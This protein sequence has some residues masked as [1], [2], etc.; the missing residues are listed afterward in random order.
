MS[1]S[2]SEHVNKSSSSPHSPS[3]P[4]DTTQGAYRPSSASPI[5]PSAYQY[6]GTTATRDAAPSRSSRHSEGYPSWLPRRPPP[7]APA[8]TVGT[9]TPAPFDRDY[10]A[11]DEDLD[12]DAEMRHLD[13]Q[14]GEFG[15]LDRPLTG[16]DADEEE[17]SPV[18]PNPLLLG[19][20]KPTPRSVRIVNLERA[21]A[22]MQITEELRTPKAAATAAGQGRPHSHPS[23]AT[24][25]AYWKGRQN[26]VSSGSTAVAHPGA[27]AVP[28][29]GWPRPHTMFDSVA[30]SWFPPGA[31]PDS[32]EPRPRP[33]FN[34]RGLH[35]EL[36]R[37]PSLWMKVY[38]RLWPLLVLAHLPL[39]TFLDFNTA[40]MLIQVSKYPLPNSAPSSSKNWALG[41]AA[42]IA[43]WLVWILVIFV[44]YELVYSF[45][46]KWR[47]RRPLIFPLYLSSP[48]YTF[49]CMTSFNTFCF[50]QH[51][52]WTA[53][54]PIS[55][56][57]P[58]ASTSPRSSVEDARRRDEVDEDPEKEIEREVAA[59]QGQQHHH[60]T[61]SASSSGSSAQEDD[62]ALGRHRRSSSSP[63]NGNDKKTPL[64]VQWKKN[65]KHTRRFW[66]QITWRDGLAETFNLYAQNLPNVV[67]LLPRAGLAL[68]LLLM[69][70]SSV[71]AGPSSSTAASRRE[72]TFFDRD[73]MLSNYA[74]GI[75]WAN[76]AWTAWR[77]G[78]LFVSWVGLWILSGHA[79]AG[80]CGPRDK[81]EEEE[82]H[83][84]SASL[85]RSRR[86]PY[87]TEEEV[88]EGK[89]Q[90]APRANGHKKTTSKTPLGPHKRKP[91]WY[92]M[93][94]SVDDDDDILPWQWRECTRARV[95]DAWEFCVVGDGGR[96]R[97]GVDSK[98]L[99]TIPAS[100]DR[101]PSTPP[102]S[103]NRRL[104][105]DKG[106][107]LDDM[108]VQ[109]VLAAVGIPTPGV[110]TPAKRG[111]LRKELFEAPGSPTKR[112]GG[113]PVLTSPTMLGREDEDDGRE[114]DGA[115]RKS[116]LP[117][118]KLPYPFAQQ[119]SGYVSSKE[120]VAESGTGVPFPAKEKKTS[121]KKS[122]S[123]GSSAKSGSS[124]S[125]DKSQ[126][127]DD[128]DHDDEQE[129]EGEP[130]P[131]SSSHNY[132]SES[133]SSSPVSSRNRRA[134][135]H[136][137]ESNSMSSLGNP[138]APSSAAFV[139]RGF[140][141]PPK[142]Q[143]TVSGGTAYTAT[144]SA[145]GTQGHG[146]RSS[147]GS[148]VTNI[149]STSG[150]GGTSGERGG[151]S[152]ASP[153]GARTRFPFL[154]GP[155]V[156][157]SPSSPGGGVVGIG[158]TGPSTHFGVHGRRVTVQHTGGTTTSGTTSGHSRGLSHASGFS[159]LSNLS[160]GV[161]SDQGY[162]AS[163]SGEGDGDLDVEMEI[164]EEAARHQQDP[165]IT[166]R[167]RT[168][169]NESGQSA[170]SGVIPM[171]RRHPHAGR[172][173]TSPAASAPGAS[174]GSD[175]GSGSA[176]SKSS[177]SRPGGIAFP[178]SDVENTTTE[179]GMVTGYA[180]GRLGMEMLSIEASDSLARRVRE[181]AARGGIPV[182]HDDEDDENE[183]DHDNTQPREAGGN[184]EE[185]QDNDDMYVDD[186]D[187]KSDGLGELDEEA[188]G[189]REDRVGLLTL[190][191]SPSAASLHHS[192]RSSALAV[193]QLG[194]LLP[195]AIAGSSSD[196]SGGRRSRRSSAAATSRRS[197][198]SLGASPSRSRHSS[199]VRSTRT[200]LAAPS[201]PSA[202]TARR[203]SLLSAARSR[204]SSF[205]VRV[206]ERAQSLMQSV[207]GGGGA[208]GASASGDGSGVRERTTSEI[209]GAGRHRRLGSGDAS[210]VSHPAVAAQPLGM[211]SVSGQSGESSGSSGQSAVQHRRD[212]GQ[213]QHVEDD[214]SSSGHSRNGSVA[215]HG[216]NYTF[217][218]PIPFLSQQRSREEIPPVPELE[219]HE[220]VQEPISPPAAPRER[221]TSVAHSSSSFGEEI[222]YSPTSATP[223]QSGLTT[224]VPRAQLPTF[225]AQQQEHEGDLNA[226]WAQSLLQPPGQRWAGRDRSLSPSSNDGSGS[227][228]VM[229]S[230]AAESFVTAPADARSMLT[231]TTTTGGDSSEAATLTGSWE[232][233]RGSGF[234]GAFLSGT[235]AAA[236][237]SGRGRGRRESGMVE[238]VGEDGVMGASGL[239]EGRVV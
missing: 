187:D 34:T 205:G 126:H 77:V 210:M 128:E 102:K 217:G 145:A 174:S 179:L 18:A 56:E 235:S 72:S 96:L 81:W 161:G 101:P 63:H 181:R 39:Q 132:S 4:H 148:A 78:V 67:V 7:P 188:R 233:R 190:S 76:V 41:A 60:R 64:D 230:S 180:S 85:A 219:R 37:S 80:I 35:L 160:A 74:E 113:S 196:V 141:S 70:S 53:F 147:I 197:R 185:E 65:L 133:G 150:V 36:L 46:R 149:T 146:H 200:S 21:P 109:K 140:P 157:S 232:E 95:Q 173:R 115:T 33:R 97:W 130:E 99:S 50:M 176:N 42:Y 104:A 124:S 142:R 31:A 86:A 69:F 59:Q 151:S 105:G 222:F 91:S 118:L 20:R 122:S 206:R 58:S 10:F 218:R 155:P 106:G 177:G 127:D 221:T 236:A 123:K 170:G 204:A 87:P 110:P 125:V 136:N 44:V 153:L 100:M 47:V 88:K 107:D 195:R 40:Y 83:R 175:S 52:R 228:E 189:E 137:S 89:S 116:S 82:L 119:G 93:S 134:Q 43:C 202:M 26:R 28:S 237:A 6:G 2:S 213:L 22:G 214:Y 159:G 62:P 226:P 12:L 19:G 199:Y 139:S 73:G 51:L 66:S 168:S 84:L 16:T 152:N 11:T 220:E 117:L 184:D 92:S 239:G 223:L 79:C 198:E 103:T 165:T 120:G 14:Y 162:A 182:Y 193:D 238:R 201:S 216:E 194:Q 171:P 98:R 29:R 211:R 229:L 3:S 13:A 225:E 75:L 163:G 203:D 143:Y 55:P 27:A 156:P 45:A 131:S 164:E 71:N 192:P 208:P 61:D 144:T 94:S 48:G 1:A 9:S 121:S 186:D 209:G 8:S 15:R 172:S 38:Y 207:V 167:D 135:S 158:A 5:P 191:V 23:Y 24:S 224:P 30:S 138:I 17:E 183:D 112:G 68:G 49:A 32:L 227:G 54:V 166:A 231:M 129:P 25:Y 234:V 215:S 90:S 57:V 212:Y 108:D 154:S 111:A 178:T 114:E 169:S